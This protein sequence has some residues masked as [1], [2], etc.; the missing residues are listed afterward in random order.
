MAFR[1]AAIG[2]AVPLCLGVFALILSLLPLEAFATAGK[3]VAHDQ[4]RLRLVA[5]GKTTTPAEGEETISLGLQ[6]DLSPGWKIYWRT[7]GDAGLP[8]TIDWD[9]SQNLSG[10]EMLWPVPHRFSLFGLETFGYGDEVVFPLIA[11][12]E[13]PGEPVR[14]KANVNFLICEEICIPYQDQVTLNLSGG[15]FERTAHA[16]LIDN[17]KGQVPG[18]GAESGLSIEE[19][20]LI[21]TVEAPELQ[22]RVRSDLSLEAPDLLVEAPPNFSFGV[23]VAEI[24]SDGR[25]AVLRVAALTGP[26]GGVL[27]GKPLT[28]TVTDGLRGIEQG[29]MARFTAPPVEAPKEDA[30]TLIGILG[31]ALIGGLILNLMPCV[32]P[33]LSIKLLSVVG[34]GGRERREI[35]TGFLA[36]AAGIVF[37]FL[38]L[39]SG[40]I[41]VKAA[42]MTV[43]WGIQFQQPLFLAA[44]AVVVTLFACNL[45]GFF[46]IRLPSSIGTAAAQSGGKGPLGSFATGAFATLLATPCSAPFLGTAVGFALSRGVTEIYAVFAVLG[47]GLALPYLL[48]AVFPAIAGRMPKPGA[49][50]IVLRRVLGVALLATAVWLLSVLISQIGWQG[51]IIAAALLTALAAV[52]WWNHR[53]KSGADPSS[54][55]LRFA[56]PIAVV[57]LAVAT[58][59]V[60][61]R[62]GQ[63]MDSERVS[64]EAWLPLDKPQI[65]ATVAEGRLVF[66]DVTADWCITC[67]V[68]KKLVLD[69]ETIAARLAA[70]DIVT[71]RGDWTLP[72]DEISAYLSEFGRYGIPFNAVYGPGA[73]EGI[74][75][76]ELLTVDAVNEALA[77]AAGKTQAGG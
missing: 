46:E 41:A 52:L 23:P 67:Q 36:S 66:V 44:M 8:P 47:L 1:C 70:P 64:A 60:P 74:A 22:V 71:M 76:P 59:V 77:K 4:V 54:R 25:E 61:E 57:L 29:I 42:G 21:G 2:K 72:N 15:P 10:A 56:T 11:R 28:V 34:Q 33:V 37:S 19:A 9:G 6:F 43:G 35:R 58:I 7:P 49:W 38:V 3:W 14:L 32:L 51:A 40:L 16:F 62:L 26:A 12:L 55:E 53:R 68:N 18:F 30:M 13:T 45:F 31:L 48:V 75:L 63:K 50:M 39:A 20:A 73:P 17:Y 27:E 24:S 5:A 69:S 65:A